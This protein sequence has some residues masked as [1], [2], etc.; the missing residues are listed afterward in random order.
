MPRD[1]EAGMP[2]TPDEDRLDAESPRREASMRFEI[3]GGA[4]GEGALR[5]AMDPANQS[6]AEALRL[7]YR[8]LQ[9]A[10]LGLLVTF[11]FSGFQTVKEGY[12]GVKTIFGRV[13]GVGADAQLAPGL[14]PFWPYPVG[15]IVVF[16]A[17]NTVSLRNEF[18]PKLQGT[19]QR[20]IEIADTS[21]PIRPGVDG[22]V[23]TGDGDL[24]HLQLSAEYAIDDVSA[25]VSHVDRAT[26]DTVVRKALARGA[27]LAAAVTPLNDLL[28][29]REE[30]MR[31]RAGG[32][33]AEGPA[34]G[35]A[36]PAGGAPAE[37]AAE[38]PAADDAASAAAVASDPDGMRRRS[39]RRGELELLIR[40]RAQQMLDELECGIRL[41][42]VSVPE[43]IAPLAVENKF[44]MAQVMREQAKESIDRA[45]K[46]A[47]ASLVAAAGPAY[48]EVL[49]G[50]RRYEAALMIGDDALA[51]SLL[52]ELGARLERGDI[53][54]EA[55]IAINRARAYQ[56]TLLAALREETQ[57]L[58]SLVPS[59]RENPRQLVRQL[60]LDAV[61]QVFADGRDEIE[62]FSVPPNLGLVQIAATSSPDV[63]QKRREA[64]LR[65]KKLEADAMG[66]ML[67]R[68]QLNLRQII[69]DGPGR[70]LNPEG[71]G[72][73]GR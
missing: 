23:I 31:A 9:I 47:R 72:G 11:L 18:W 52:T 24:A 33:A 26:V 48:E 16:E 6:L 19:V 36:A 39:M 67:P 30:P 12:T 66:L 8:V 58:E 38:A 69:T 71:T 59:F 21:N 51:D 61:R 63:M 15:E 17:R 64:E 35:G 13:Q 54:G 32:A 42:S 57:R 41:I 10:I 7:S 49:E 50:V 5:E 34:A 60:W 62:V 40:E 70:R 37:P 4:G 3:A 1:P 28:A 43:R 65:R 29:D 46:D 27:V 45:H 53:G 2:D 55:A 56:G 25:F 20:A 44:A 22:S 14:E 73:Q 68:S